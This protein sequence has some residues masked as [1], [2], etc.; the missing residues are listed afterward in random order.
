MSAQQIPV[1]VVGGGAAGLAAALTLGRY[2]I[3]TV[4]VEK[5]TVPSTRPRATVASTRSMELIRSWGLEAPV[6]AQSVD[7]DVWLWECATLISADAGRAHAVGYPSREQAALVSPAAPAVVAQDRLE[8]VLREHLATLPSVRVEA[9]VEVASVRSLPDGVHVTTEDGRS[10]WA[11]Y[12]VGADGAHSTVR[13]QL[14]VTVHGGD[15]GALSGIQAVVHAPLLPLLGPRLYGLYSVTET[16]G[17]FLPAG[18]DDRWVYAPAVEPGVAAPRPHQI[19]ERLRRGAGLAH[20]PVHLESV[21]AFRSPAQLA[22]RFRDGDVFLAGDAAHRVTPRGGTGMNI[23]LQGGA[24]LA[25]KLAWV[26]AGWAGPELL[27]TYEAERR[28]VAEHVVARSLDPDGSRRSVRGELAVDLG[29]RVPHVALPDGRSSLDLLGPGWTVFAGPAA[30]AP[31]RAL[32]AGRAGS[33]PVTVHT[34]DALGARALGLSPDA[35]LLAR[36]DGVPAVLQAG[37]V[38]RAETAFATAA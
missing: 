12:V 17:L 2:G 4:L 14:G 35:A 7:A 21:R 28:P 36:P 30:D 16:P 34:L 27:D 13:R 15:A 26:L 11:R 38:T 8:T 29:P 32:A 24:D 20:L 19:I 5:R 31:A 3:E 9:G 1:L 18:P 23:A 10:L 37:A 6:R 22:E 25:W 33:A